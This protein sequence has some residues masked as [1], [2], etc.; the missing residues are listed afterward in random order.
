MAFYLPGLYEGGAER[1]ILNLVKGI[2]A[3]GYRVDLL[4]ARAEGPYMMQLPACVRLID[5]DASRVICSV[6]ALVRYLKKEQPS[7][8]LSAMYANIPALLAKRLSRYRGRLIISEHNTLSVVSNGSSDLRWRIYPRLA[9][10]CYLWADEIVAVSNGVADDLA[11]VAHL[12]R[13]RIRVVYNPVVTPDLYEKSAEPLQHPWFQAGQPPVI[14]SV[15]RLTPQKGFD[16]LIRAFAQV[17]KKSR[18]RLLILGEGEERTALEDLASALGIERDVSLPGFV[19]N[20][21]NYM[22]RAAVFA[23]SSRW[24]GLP[25]VLVEAMSLN[26]PV[27]SS[28]CPSG[29]REILQHGKYGSLVPVGATHELAHAILDTLETKRLSLPARS[30]RPYE[31]TEVLGQYIAILTGSSSS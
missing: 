19:S 8:L 3:R 1:I 7:A 2:A 30:W 5:L 23:L 25:T 15:G 17:R 13:E 31:L 21:Y 22:A 20:P 11:N 27:V 9:Q 12:P 10:W 14:L 29:P 16:L 28:D 4:L 26:L 24:E 6:P 18:A